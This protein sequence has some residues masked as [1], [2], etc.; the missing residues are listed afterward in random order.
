MVESVAIEFD[1]EPAVRGDLHL[2]LNS[3][4]PAVVL[5]HG[6]GGDRNGPLLKALAETFAAAGS[7]AL[8]CDLPYR[9]R[10]PKGPPSPSGAAR[11]REGLR[12]AMTALGERTGARVC[13][14]GSSYGGRQASIL[15]SETP[16]ETPPAA[17]LLLSYPLHPPGKPERLR[18]EHFPAVSA[19]A[20]FA[21]G[22]RDAFGTIE[23][24]E[25]HMRRLGGPSELLVFEGAA[26]GLVGR[27]DSEAKTRVTA[28]RIVEGFFAFIKRCV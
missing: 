9:Q 4:R 5:T 13:L 25:T 23:E 6:A 28:E 11:D 18:V 7:A 16:S 1:D 12:R 14:G 8:R 22:S 19:P 2:P 17:L 26:H 27:R 10:R 3:S 15:A 20:F 21:H 24:M